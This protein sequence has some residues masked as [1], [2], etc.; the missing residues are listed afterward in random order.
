MLQLAKLE[1]RKGSNHL[2]HWKPER[3]AVFQ[4]LQWEL[5]KPLAP[6]LMNLDKPLVTSTDASD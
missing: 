2:R 6:F 4:D 1:A 3:D 5:L